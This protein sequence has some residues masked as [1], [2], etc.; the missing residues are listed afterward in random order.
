MTEGFKDQGPYSSSAAYFG[1]VADAA[2]HRLGI[3]DGLIPWEALAAF[4]FHDVVRS[5]ALYSDGNKQFSLNHMD[6]GTQNILVDDEFNFLAIIDWGFAQTTPWAVNHYPMPFPLTG[7]DGEIQGILK[8]P[9][10]LAHAN[11]VRQ[12]TARRL[13]VQKFRDAEAELQEEGRRPEGSFAEVLDGRPSRVF[14]C[15]SS[16]GRLEEAD[17]G[18][19]RE[20]VRLAFGFDGE[21]ADKS[22]R[23]M[24]VEARSVLHTCKDGSV[25]C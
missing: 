21:R 14:A 19:V 4:V 5:T 10:H 9:E 23:S 17:E 25:G 20:M 8:D 3:P 11:V 18:L 13:Y 12:E 15:S 22:L 24:E 16:L 6:L 2:I 1:E 7:S